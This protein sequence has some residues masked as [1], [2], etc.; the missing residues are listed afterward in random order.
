MSNPILIE[1]T[2]G[3]LVES[4]HRGAVAVARSSGAPLLALG[5]VN[6]PVYPRSAIKMIQALPLVET[7]AADRFGFGDAEIA[8]ACGSHAGTERHVAVARGMIAKLNLDDGCLA[9][10]AAIPLA[11]K[12]AQAL[13]ASGKP[14]TPFHHNCS[15]KHAGMLA[16]ALTLGAPVAGYTDAA[17]E[18]QRH[19][20]RVL[21]D[22]TGL[23]LESDVCGID[24]CCVPTWA[25]GLESLA[26]L[27]AKLAT[28]EGLTPDR[29]RAVQ[30]I[31]AACWA[32]PELVSGRGRADTVVMAALPQRI[33]MKNGAEGVYCGAIPQLGLG[34][35]L[36]VDDGAQRACAAA[37]MP[38]IERLVPQARGLVHRSVLKTAKGIEAGQIRTSTAYERALDRLEG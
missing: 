20:H 1:V 14:A 3:R 4:F 24:G 17:H 16:A 33:F 7:G 26:R 10:G 30:R 2:R 34:F 38:L 11:A 36:K 12:A 22:V 15:G 25:M 32:E 23:A 35:A 9:C 5:D 13:A 29:Q 19:V 28:G 6:R 18:V 31:M 27:F 37:V 8:L 21:A